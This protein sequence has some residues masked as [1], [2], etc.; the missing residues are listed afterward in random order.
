MRQAGWIVAGTVIFLAFVPGSLPAQ[1][2][3]ENKSFS[4][5]A[6]D[7]LV[8]QNDYGRVQI[9]AWESSLVDAQIRKNKSTRNGKE[10]IRVAAQKSGGRIF[11]YCFFSGSG[12]E[13]V[14]MEI[15]VPLSL[16]V[17][18]SGANP[19]VDL[20]GI[21]GFVRIQTFTGGISAENL[22][23][24][25]S[26]ISDSGDIFYRTIA[27]ARGDVRMETNSGGI[28]CELSE[29]LN[30]RAWLRAGGAITWDKE[31]EVRAT[32]VEKQLG[33]FGPLL[34]AGS[35][36]GNVTVLLKDAVLA[37]T[38][39]VELPKPKEVRRETPAGSAPP[40]DTPAERP[41][42]S[43][44]PG[45]GTKA[46]SS[47]GPGNES[48]QTPDTARPSTPDK[49]D[50]P[51]T[52]SPTPSPPSRS[53]AGEF[54]VKVSVDSV[55][56]NVSVR[57]RY[58][59]RSI[60]GLGKDDF[61]VYEDQVPQQIEQLMPSEAPFNLLLL[62][63]VSGS[64]RSFL[65]L[66]KQASIDFTRQI[67]ANDRVAVAVFNSGVHLVRGFTNDRAAAAQ[68][69]QSIRS[70][71]GTAF[72]DALLTSIDDYMRVVE[73][74]SAIV[75]FTDGVDNQLEGQ[76][77]QGSRTPFPQLYRR[78]QE[79]EPIIYTI[80]LD[81][82]NRVVPMTR[83]GGSGSVMIDILGGVL[84]GR[85]P[86][87]YPGTSQVPGTNHAVYQEAREQLMMIAEQTGGRMYT[88]DRI[89][90]L[91]RVYGEIAD[92][93]RI[94]YQLGYNSTNRAQDGRWREVHVQV[95][96]YPDAV[97][98]TRKGYYARNEPSRASQIRP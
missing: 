89:E 45:A 15:R 87:G 76:R 16:N 62:L 11:V 81:T 17:V 22:T 44:N 37:P 36:A 91:A 85:R 56:L 58:S 1:V 82:E 75:V 7:T 94:Q 20:H 47:P 31:A 64:T 10:S 93:L 35:L 33:T 65:H 9:T 41:R 86:G 3:S 30:L 61:Q 95:H 90:D 4:T 12:G 50:D 23:S 48:K 21:Q 39:P 72:Y 67:K 80:F 54:A 25:V 51:A 69:I 43:R 79:I 96:G 2:S 52:E 97:V 73:G 42:L 63:D 71:G 13:S 55:F 83:G 88:P 98:R 18:V 27:Q 19:D 77:S 6:G 34:Y 68:A 84:G 29:K 78:I 28:L 8:V 46:P 32:N 49:P 59:N 66:M 57:D 38:I 74:R 70:G 14:D 53:T 26:L 40:P 92:D 24:S 5:Q 60:V